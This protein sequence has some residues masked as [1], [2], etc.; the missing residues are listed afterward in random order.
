[1]KTPYRKASGANARLARSKAKLGRALLGLAG[2]LSVS[3]AAARVSAPPVSNS[4]FIP[5]MS[6]GKPG[7]EFSLS[8]N[9]NAAYHVRFDAGRGKAYN[10]R[11]R[12]ASEYTDTTTQE[13]S[14]FLQLTGSNGRLQIYY[15]TV[16]VGE[17]RTTST[18]NLRYKLN[19]RSR[20]MS[21]NCDKLEIYNAPLPGKA[22]GTDFVN[23]W[24]LGYNG[25][26][27]KISE[28]DEAKFGKWL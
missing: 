26:A 14:F 16:L 11:S 1:M 7:N 18:I 5:L 17:H 13:P 27:A 9:K 23:V 21:F 10:L 15:D 19:G 3:C 20:T 28:Y 6:C 25:Y 8:I 2:L 12:M 24:S 22:T 4:A